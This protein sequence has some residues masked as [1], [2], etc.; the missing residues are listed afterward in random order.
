[1]F[2]VL[3]WAQITARPDVPCPI[4]FTLEE[5]QECLRLDELEQEAAEQLQSS[6]EMLGLD[7]EGWGSCDNFDAT[8]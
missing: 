3:H 2:L 5:E 1:M 4:S 7:P 6:M 8:R